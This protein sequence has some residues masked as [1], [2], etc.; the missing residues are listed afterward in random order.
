MKEKIYIFVLGML[1]IMLVLACG[2]LWKAREASIAEAEHIQDEIK[3]ERD[4]F[5]ERTKSLEAQNVQSMQEI[6]ELSSKTADL[7]KKSQGDPPLS[8]EPHEVGDYQLELRPKQD[9]N[10]AL[11]SPSSTMILPFRD[12][13]AVLGNGT[14]AYEDSGI[15]GVGLLHQT[16]GDMCFSWDYRY[17]VDVSSGKVLQVGDTATCTKELFSINNYQGR[18]VEFS[19]EVDSPCNPN[20]SDNVC[21]EDTIQTT[22]GLLMN[23]KKVFDLNIE[24]ACSEGA[25][26]G[27]CDVKDQPFFTFVGVDEGLNSVEFD[28]QVHESDDQGG[29][30]TLYSLIL[31]LESLDLAQRE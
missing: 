10:M 4:Y 24:S 30:K 11:I 26:E 31:D 5:Q 7:Q 1:C 29:R 22:T 12:M 28:V 14:F 20:G 25:I 21:G 15:E 17:Y 8:Y 18:D 13:P 19:F 9:Y 16:D 3:Q 23:G 2:V 27:I 6:V